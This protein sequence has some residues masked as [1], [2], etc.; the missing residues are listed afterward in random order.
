MNPLWNLVRG[1]YRP[2]PDMGILQMQIL[3]NKTGDSFRIFHGSCNEI[4][5]ETSTVDSERTFL[6]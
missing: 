3:I 4:A 5:I 1:E 6:Y 2:T